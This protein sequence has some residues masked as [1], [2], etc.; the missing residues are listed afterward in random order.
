MKLKRPCYYIK[1]NGEAC[2]AHALRGRGYCFF[3]HEAAKRD[4]RR[5]RFSNANSIDIDVLPFE[6]AESIQVSI[7]EVAMALLDRRVDPHTAT[8]LLYSMQL[9]VSNLQNVNNAPRQLRPYAVDVLPGDDF[10]ADFIDEKAD[11][12]AEPTSKNPPEACKTCPEDNI[13]ENCEHFVDDRDLGLPSLEVVPPRFSVPITARKP[14]ASAFD[15]LGRSR[16]PQLLP[17]E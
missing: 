10:D 12:V 6:D 14:P 1:T 4:S 3:H 11:A 8:T 5:L 16:T 2:G 13:C 9:A 15:L 7:S 17:S